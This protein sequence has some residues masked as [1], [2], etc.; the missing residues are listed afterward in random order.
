M[1]AVKRIA[2]GTLLVMVALVFSLSVGTVWAAEQAAPNTP[3][4]TVEAAAAPQQTKEAKAVVQ[5]GEKT[6]EHATAEQEKEEPIV[7]KR[8]LKDLLW[9]C[10][11]FAALVIILVKFGAKPIGASL[12]ERKNKIKTDIED[13]EARKAEAE[14]SYK[15]FEAKLEGIESEIETIVEKAVAQAEVE[16][17]RIIEKA[18]QAATDIQ[19]Q[20]EMAIQHEIVEAKRTL[21]NDI[22]DQA[23][24]MAEELIKKNLTAKDQVNI[25]EDYLAKVGAVQ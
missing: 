20:A 24:V 8:G 5:K 16:K 11:N 14:K 4:K 23:A 22:A 9:R 10:I 18:E 3:A 21:K 17:A 2:R 7:T 1:K 19:R 25:V 6:V 13:L 12:S 15:E